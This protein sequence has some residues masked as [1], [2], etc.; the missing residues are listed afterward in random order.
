MT[1][2]RLPKVRGGEVEKPICLLMSTVPTLTDVCVLALTR[3]LF[4]WQ[5]TAGSF[6]NFMQEHQPASSAADLWM[7]A[8]HQIKLSAT[9]GQ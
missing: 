1:A 5:P 6:L 3:I 2:V 4:T 9:C 7:H 8:L